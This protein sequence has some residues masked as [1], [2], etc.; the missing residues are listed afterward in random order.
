[1]FLSQT[2]GPISCEPPPDGLTAPGPALP[3]PGVPG[4]DAPELPGPEGPELPGVEEPELP[5]PEAPGL[6][7]P[8][9]PDPCPEGWE[10]DG[11][12]C[13]ADGTG[14]TMAAVS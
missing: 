8:T 2:P 10:A 1:M 14:C 4:P 7:G 9:V 3:G 12:A 6:P 13:V 11:A 5:G